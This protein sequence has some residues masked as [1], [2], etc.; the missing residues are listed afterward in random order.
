MKVQL[1]TFGTSFWNLLVI[2][3]SVILP[4]FDP[5]LGFSNMDQPPPTCINMRLQP[6]SVT[7]TRSL[8]RR[9]GLVQSTSH[10]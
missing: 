6:L 7:K 3:A 4:Q 5:N 8:A 10:S 2:F 1:S 9:R